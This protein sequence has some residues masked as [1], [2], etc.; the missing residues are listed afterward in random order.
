MPDAPAGPDYPSI[1]RVVA[2]WS[3]A[4][5]ARKLL[6]DL[7]VGRRRA[8]APVLAGG[9]YEELAVRGC[10]LDMLTWVPARRRDIRERGFD[11]AELI[12]K[13]LARATGLPCKPLLRRST[14][15]LPDQVGLSRTARTENLRG[16]FAAL[17]CLGTIGLVDDLITTGATARSCAGALRA[18]GAGSVYGLVVCRA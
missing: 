18:A 11:H 4:G 12:A 9:I 7:K 15:K 16:A 10:A 2:R 8:V 14:Q 17:Y 13:A 3:Y 1:D 5:A 6:L